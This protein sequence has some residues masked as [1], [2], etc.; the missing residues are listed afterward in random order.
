MSSKYKIKKVTKIDKDVLK[1]ACIAGES[2][3]KMAYKMKTYEIDLLDALYVEQEAIKLKSNYYEYFKKFSPNILM[4]ISISAMN[5][6]SYLSSNK[7]GVIRYT[8]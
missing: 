4:N 8:I 3:L 1:Q 7:K 5:I 2:S 6:A